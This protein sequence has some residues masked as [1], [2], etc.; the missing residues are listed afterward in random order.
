MIKLESEY[1]KIYTLVQIR[2]IITRIRVRGK[3]VN[4][5][6]HKKD[7]SLASKDS[8]EINVMR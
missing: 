3:S 8:R 7:F 1:G 5:E 6:E 4:G 2:Y